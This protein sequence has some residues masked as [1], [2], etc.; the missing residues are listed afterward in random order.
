FPRLMFRGEAEPIVWPANVGDTMVFTGTGLIKKKLKPV[1]PG[2]DPQP[3]SY[4][5]EQWTA[6]LNQYADTIDTPIAAWIVAIASLMYRNAQQLGLSAGQSLNALVRNRM[7]AAALSGWT[8]AD[9]AQSGVT[10]LRVKRL[11]GF[12][13]ARRPDLSSTGGS[14]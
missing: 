9:G 6:Q 2:T 14:V 3:S 11:N 7:Y 4:Q 10:T 8:V 12:T 1:T 5:Y 13:R